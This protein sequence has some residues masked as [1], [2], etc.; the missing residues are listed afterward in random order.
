MLDKYIY[1][2]I[3]IYK[4]K[5]REYSTSMNNLRNQPNGNQN[6]QEINLF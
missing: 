6:W 2:Y 4:I 5:K 1:I 3:Y